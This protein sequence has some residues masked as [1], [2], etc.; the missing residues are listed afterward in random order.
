MEKVY[1]E[2]DKCHKKFTIRKSL[3]YHKRE[4]HLKCLFHDISFMTDL[5]MDTHLKEEHTNKYL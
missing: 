5:E 1:Y 3:G 2:C 4:V